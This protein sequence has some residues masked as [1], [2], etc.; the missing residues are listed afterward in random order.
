MI[1]SIHFKNGEIQLW[2]H[3]SENLVKHFHDV[4]K[5]YHDIIPTA[6]MTYSFQLNNTWMNLLYQ[7]MIKC[8]LL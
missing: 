6:H 1:T 7:D 8:K 4:L 3:R 2:N 5:L